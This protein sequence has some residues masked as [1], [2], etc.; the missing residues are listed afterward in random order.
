M[1]TDIIL[2]FLSQSHVHHMHLWGE[3]LIDIRLPELSRKVRTR[4][5]QVMW[6]CPSEQAEFMSWAGL[7]AASI[8]ELHYF[9]S[10]LGKSET[11]CMV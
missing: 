3:Q 11:T 7:K 1:R 8:M 10:A 4:H 6:D 9:S 2:L 5:V